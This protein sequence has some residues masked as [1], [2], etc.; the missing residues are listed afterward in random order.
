[1]KK[2]TLLCALGVS[3]G[4]LVTKMKKAAQE[5][6]FDAEIAAYSVD[7]FDTVEQDSDMILLGPQVSYMVKGLKAKKPDL[8]IEAI[9]M[10]AYGMMDGK[11]VVM[12]C[13][14]VLG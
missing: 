1:M 12:H 6:H 7:E 8:P 5:L 4:M 3:T 9:D 13:M 2:I 14:D 10:L 11:K